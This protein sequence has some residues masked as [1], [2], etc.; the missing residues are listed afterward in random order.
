[1]NIYLYLND[2]QTGPYSEEQL[3]E[4]LVAGN[5]NPLQLAWHEGLTE[6]QP[7]NTILSIVPVFPPPP[8]R[9]QSTIVTTQL[10]SKPIKAVLALFGLAFVVC[11]S[12]AAITLEQGWD[13][14]IY[15]FYAAGI[16]GIGFVITKGVRWW[17][18]E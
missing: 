14:S 9:L 6:W 16:M 15:W 8:S 1:M 7:L 17:K 3:R 13:G 12:G 10:T 18:H 4:M 5:I 2:Q 11:G